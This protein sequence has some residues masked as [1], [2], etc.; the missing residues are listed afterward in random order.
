MGFFALAA[1]SM[2]STA[3]QSMRM[4]IEGNARFASSYSE[5]PRQDQAR[6]VE[7]SKGQHPIAAV[8]CCSDSRVSPELVFDQGLGDL[9][10]VRCAGNTVDAV[11]MGSLEYAVEHLG[12]HLIIVMGHEKC[13]AVK[14]AL[15][16]E[17]LPGSVPAVVKPI[18][19]AITAAKH[20]KGDPLHNTIV[21]NVRGVVRRMRVADSLI[22][23]EIKSGK[24]T[25][26]PM[27][28]DLTTGKAIVLK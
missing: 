15:A 9:F 16:G 4:L 20:L 14:A 10:V 11:S 5:H 23:K 22:K 1:F 12:V 26:V 3:R 8:V 18:K 13:G 19:S 7:V 27:D 28:Y 21:E 2:E 25:I 6:R 17:P 24:V